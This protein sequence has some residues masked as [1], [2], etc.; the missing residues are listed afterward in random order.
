ML[1]QQG[2]LD[3][4][5]VIVT[6]DNGMPFPRIKGQAYEYSN[7]LPLVIMWK[8]GLKK[9]GRVVDDIVNFIDFAPTFLELAQVKQAKSGMKPIEGLSLTDILYSKKDGQVNP[10]RDHILIGKERHDIGRPHDWGYPIR[11]I[12]KD[13]FLYVK[14]YKVDRWPAGDPVTGYLNCDGSP[15]KT[16]CLESRTDPDT[17][18]YWQWSFGK[19]VSEEL[20]QISNDP[21]CMNNLA[22]DPA[23]QMIKNK[24]QKQMVKELKEQDDPRMFGNGSVFDEYPYAQP[25]Y[26][27]YYEK[28]MAGE[29]IEA[30]WVNP[31]DYETKPI[32][33]P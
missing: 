12:V 32:Q 33:E 3:N 30:N 15:T 23:Y 24:L 10:D 26:R 11:G 1:E 25:M 4:T 13:G 19:R 8:E 27:H 31:S 21:D 29:H 16:V 7:H 2:E 20:Y 14:N 28:Y 9:P 22:D 5:V 18:Q 17:E 6:A